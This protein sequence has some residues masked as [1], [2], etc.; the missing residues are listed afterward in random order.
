MMRSLTLPRLLSS[1]AIIG[2]STLSPSV[3]AQVAAGKSDATAA[4]A[5]AACE[6]AARQTLGAQGVRPVEVTFIGAPAVQPSLSNENQTVLRGAGRARGTGG[7]RTFNYSCDV[8]L[9]TSEAV[10][11]VLRDAT[12]IVAEAAPARA[13]AEPDLSELSPA[14]CESSAVGALQKRWPRV[15]KIT[16]D[17]AT[18]SFR[19]PSAN[20]AE[21]HGTGLALPA[22]GSPVTVFEFECAIDPRDGRVLRTSLSG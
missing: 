18:R 20:V 1:A 14:A 17:S 16:F 10:G 12:P 11:L 19:Q 9:R 7:V 3:H 6:R 13:P 21:F 5:L 2:L 8:D 4:S 15:S 22:Q